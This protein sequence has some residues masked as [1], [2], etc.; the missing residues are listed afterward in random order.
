MANR[1]PRLGRANHPTA[2]SP[3]AEVKSLSERQAQNGTATTQE[4]PLVEGNELIRRID[5]PLPGDVVRRATGKSQ[6]RADLARQRSNR[7]FF[8]DAFS[9]KPASPARERVGGD[10]MVMVDVKTNVIIS[11]EFTFITS[12]ASHL[13]TRYHRPVSSIVITLHHGACM[14]FGGSFGPAYVMTVFALPSQLLP[15][16]NKRNAALIQRHMEEILGVGP[17]RGVLRFVPTKEEH[18]ASGGRTVAAEVEEAE[19]GVWGHGGG[20]K[21]KGGETGSA[22]VVDEGVRRAGSSRSMKARRMLSVKSLASIRPPRATDIRTPDMTPPAGV[23]EGQPSILPSPNSVGR[24]ISEQTGAEPTSP[25]RKAAQRK[26]S[27]VATIF[28]RSGSRSSD[29]PALPAIADERCR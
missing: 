20:L 22:V 26:K 25:P 21:E 2:T 15:T 23:E 9:I 8:E 28:G 13:S 4:E 3:A 14:F 5:R 7:N 6:T 12:L 19:R 1:L 11:D 27:F 18:F 16:T 29:R 10:A 24:D 17:A